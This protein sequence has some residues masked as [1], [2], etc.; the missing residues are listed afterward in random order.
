[1]KPKSRLVVRI[2]GLSFAAAAISLLQS[3]K[4]CPG[5]AEICSSIEQMPI[6]QATNETATTV[7]EDPGTVKVIHGSQSAHNSNALLKLEQSIPLPTYVTKAAVF[8]NGWHFRYSNGDH[9]V[10]GLSAAIG[11]INVMP[12]KITWD[13]YCAF[14]DSGGDKPIDVTYYFTVVAWNDSNIKAFPD[15][16]DASHFCKG[17]TPSGSDNFFYS[18]HSGNDPTALASFASF[19]TDSNFSTGRIVAMLPRGFGFNW[20]CGDDHHL[21]QLAYELSHA[22]TMIQSQTYVKG[23]GTLQPLPSPPNAHID[24]GVVSWTTNAIFKDNDSSRDYS[25]GEFVSGIGGADVD[26][27]EPPMAPMQPIEAPGWFGACL[28]GPSGV[29]QQNI[30]ID[31]VPYECAVPMLTRWDLTYG[32]LG[33]H[34]VR[35]IGMWLDNLKYDKLPNASSGTLRYTV[36]SVLHDDSGNWGAYTNKVNL[37]GLRRSGSGVIK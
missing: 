20:S 7:F 1:M 10:A 26:V 23:E 8:L 5:S 28:S 35:E 34:H 6:T 2:A 19:L 29:Q 24:T 21:L 32:C 25:F 15:Q 16:D 17:G 33:D 4:F 27:V 12:G 30:V 18:F 37:L 11:K 9:H 36:F 14:G 31:N 22:E 13:A 3:C